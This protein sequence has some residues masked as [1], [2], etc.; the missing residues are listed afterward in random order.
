MG[1]ATAV[2]AVAGVLTAAP[3]SAA[4]GVLVVSG[5]RIDDPSGC[6]QGHHWPLVVD[7]RTDQVALVLDDDNCGG[8]VVG[9]VAPGE[10]QVFEFGASVHIR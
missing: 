10:K 5:N 2:M 7:N 9:T 3:A 6:Y 4:H 1:I 8:Q